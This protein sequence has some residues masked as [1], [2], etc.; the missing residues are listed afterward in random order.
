MSPSPTKV[1]RAANT[2]FS[3]WRF[4]SIAASQSITA[5]VQGRRD[6]NAG[7]RGRDKV[8][9]V[10]LDVGQTCAKLQVSRWWGLIPVRGGLCWYVTMLRGNLG[11]LRSDEHSGR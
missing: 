5:S 7:W 8:S 2:R 11:A 9:S 10:G 6:C 1:T 4:F 3:A